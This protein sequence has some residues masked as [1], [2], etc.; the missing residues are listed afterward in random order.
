MIHLFSNAFVIT[1]IDCTSNSPTPS[2]LPHPL[3]PHLTS[4]RL[5]LPLPSLLAVYVGVYFG[6]FFFKRGALH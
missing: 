5:F 4:L 3:M 2:V 1:S 6:V